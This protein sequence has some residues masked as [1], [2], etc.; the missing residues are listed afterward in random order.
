M[1]FN[2]SKK[3]EN[4]ENYL[5]MKYLDEIVF[6]KKRRFLKIHFMIKLLI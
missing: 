1:F 4:L 2:I 5:L 6:K 3:D